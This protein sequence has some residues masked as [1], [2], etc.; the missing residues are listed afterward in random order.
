M[1]DVSLSNIL[2]L[3]TTSTESSGQSRTELAFLISLLSLCLSLSV[4][5]PPLQQT[6][7]K[8]MAEGPEE[9]PTHTRGP[10]S[11]QQVEA[12]LALLVESVGVVRPVQFVIEVNTQEP[13]L[14]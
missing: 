3:P 4:L 10:Q 9:S 14:E 1:I 11:P 5:P 13:R 8:K 7:A 6:T 2:L 12:A